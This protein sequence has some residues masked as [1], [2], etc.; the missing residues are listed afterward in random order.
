M[1][2]IYILHV[3]YMCIYCTLYKLYIYIYIYI[4]MHI[5]TIYTVKIYMLYII[6]IAK[7][8]RMCPPGYYHSANGL[9]VTH[10][11]DVRFM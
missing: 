7:K 1:Y 11:H 10:A 3:L 4:Y 5:I 6:Y 8:R 9:M 2:T